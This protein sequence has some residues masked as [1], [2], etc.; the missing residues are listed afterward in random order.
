MWP[1]TEFWPAITKKKQ[2][3]WQIC[4]SRTSQIRCEVARTRATVTCL[5]FGSVYSERKTAA[6][7]RLDLWGSSDRGLGLAQPGSPVD[8]QVH[9]EVPNKYIYNG[10]STHNMYGPSSK[11]RV[12]DKAINLRKIQQGATQWRDANNPRS[13]RRGLETCR[14]FIER[15][16][17]Q[18]FN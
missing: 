7:R 13:N 16:K 15:E 4:M 11:A 12:G 8:R 14:R 9:A 17:K 1:Q 10:M 5:T 2:H 18:A 6:L 3:F